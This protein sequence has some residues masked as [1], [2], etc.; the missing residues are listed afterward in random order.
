MA[1]IA[2]AP[3]MYEALKELWQVSFAPPGEDIGR[4]LQAVKAAEAAL[5]KATGS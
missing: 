5:A 2:A 3:E 4:L 1:L